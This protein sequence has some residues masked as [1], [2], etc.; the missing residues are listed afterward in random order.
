MYN[1]KQSVC[2]ALVHNNNAGR[3]A[4]IRPFLNELR[5]RLLERFATIETEVSNQPEIR[6]HCLPMAFLRDAVYQ[7]LI[8]EWCRYRLIRPQSLLLHAPRFFLKSINKYSSGRENW[9]RNSS[10]ETVITDK[11]IR[12]W[13]AFLE[14]R[15]DFLICFEDDAVFKE[16]SIQRLGDLLETLF[17]RNFDRLIYID[18]A[19]GCQLDEL[20]I[21]NIEKS[22]ERF[23]RHY[24]KPVTNTACV[25]LMSRPLVGVF[26]EMIIRN[27]WLRLIGIDWMMN[28]LFIKLIKDGIE[29][30][31]M[32]ADPTIFRHG[33]TTGEYA[34]WQTQELH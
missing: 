3:N 16:D 6:A 2:L 26:H 28:K 27:P 24:S 19:G 21:G 11:H 17:Q 14:T 31:C 1:G 30:D 8:R 23:F 18:L 15:G 5:S 33:T 12:A 25:Y 10:I 9:K 29:C 13:S 20:K 7:L 22:R 34:S 32:H 4:Y